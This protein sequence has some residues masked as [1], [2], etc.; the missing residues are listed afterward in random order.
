M[1]GSERRANIKAHNTID[2]NRILAFSNS[3]IDVKQK[4]LGIV[5]ASEGSTRFYFAESNLGKS[6]TARNTEYAEHARHR[7]GF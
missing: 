4:N 7:P 2:P 5:V 1:V 3:V 6:I